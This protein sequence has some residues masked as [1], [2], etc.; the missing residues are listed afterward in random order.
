MH[1]AFACSRFVGASAPTARFP[2]NRQTRSLGSKSAAAVNHFA[3]GGCGKQLSLNSRR[4]LSVRSAS[5]FDAL[6][7]LAGSSGLVA[8]EDALPG[9]DRKMAVSPK[10][11]VLGTPMEGPWPENMEVIIIANG[12]FWGSEKG[13]W[14]LPG[15]GIHS[16]AVGYAAGYS[17][18]PTYE[19]ACSGRTGHTEAVQVVYDPSKIALADILR[20]FWE[21]HDPTQGMRQGNDRGTQYRSGLYWFTEE[22]GALCKASK[23]AYEKALGRK[24]TTELAPASDYDQVFYYGEDYHQQYLAK[25]G[26]RPYCSAQPTQVSLPPFET[27]APESVKHLTPKLTQDFWDKEAPSPHCVIRSPNAPI[28]WP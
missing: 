14:R 19:E 22:Q 3:K 23:D 17:P 10:H 11:Y 26:A 18:N 2:R 9:R 8:K 21:A 1:R 12:C 20:W 7:G 15:G 27:W 4:P 13:M 25:P 28:Q 6:M 5:L 24:I 16:T